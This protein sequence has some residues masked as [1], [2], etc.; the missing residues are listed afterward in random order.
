MRD[1]KLL[2]DIAKDAH[3]DVDFF[4]EMLLHS[5]MSER[6]IMQMYMIYKFKWD[7]GQQVGKCPTWDETIFAWTEQGYAQRFADLYEPNKSVCRLVRE[8]KI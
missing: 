7:Y 4:K 6:N 8:L 5:C 3:N 2:E 1:R